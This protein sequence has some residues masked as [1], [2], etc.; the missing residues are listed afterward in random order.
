MRFVLDQSAARRRT[1]LCFLLFALILLGLAAVGGSV[2]PLALSPGVVAR[3]GGVGAAQLL[4]ALGLL[5]VLTGASLWKVRQLARQ[6]GAAVVTALGATPL[7]ELAGAA[8][9]RLRN[10]VEEMAIAA[11]VPVP[12][13]YLLADEPAINALVAGYGPADAV[14]CVTHGALERLDRAEL[15]GLVAHEFSHLLNGDMRLNLRLIGWLHGISLLADLG[16]EL[17]VTRARGSGKRSLQA[18]TLFEVVFG[19]TLYVCGSLGLGCALLIQAAVSRSRE[20]LADASAVQFTRYPQGLAGALQKIA[21]HPLQGRLYHPKARS[22]AHM[23]VGD[24][25]ASWFATHPPLLER[26]Q[27]LDPSFSAHELQRL[28]AEASIPLGKAYVAGEPPPVVR[29][30]SAAAVPMAELPSVAA[31]AALLTALPV[32]L[33]EGTRQP[34]VAWPLLLHLAGASAPALTPALAGD[35]VDLHPALRLPLAQLTFPALRQLPRARLREVLVALKARLEPRAA[36]DLSSYCL[37]R[38]L[39]RQLVAS[40]APARQRPAGRLTL[41]QGEAAI[42]A[43][44]AV[45]AEQ[46]HDSFKAAQR[47]F[48]LAIAATF[49]GRHLVY[50][51]PPLWRPALERALDGLALLVPEARTLVLEGLLCLIEA[52][53]KVKTTELELLGL[54][55]AMLEL[56]RPLVKESAS[57]T[58]DVSSRAFHRSVDASQLLSNS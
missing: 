33:R 37:A 52:D 48:L 16:R 34:D 55:C 45:V 17:L 27:Q 41:A 18:A 38:V 39:Q 21:A 35:L 49:P 6:G 56:P 1:R 40:L 23:L 19:L 25:G 26:I 47:A 32:R 42:V 2:A 44:Y 57:L 14:L 29:A 22:V 30:E 46:A 36:S 5:L 9:Q 50:T 7:D 11:A 31:A 28:R 24:A 13:L 10:V 8:A 3:L 58:D 43:L 15:Q 53:N 54:F 51:P 12:R 4:T 20:R